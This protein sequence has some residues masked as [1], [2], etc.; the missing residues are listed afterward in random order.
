MQSQSNSSF[1]YIFFVV[2]LIISFEQNLY[3]QEI[4]SLVSDT[5]QVIEIKKEPKI[6][7]SGAVWRS[8]VLPG[9]GQLY[10]ESYW[11]APIFF[12]AFATLGTMIVYNHIKYN[13]FADIV[14]HLDKDD[15]LYQNRKLWREYYRDNR[16]ISGFYLIVTYILATIDAYVGAHLYEF[17]INDDISINLGLTSKEFIPLVSINLHLK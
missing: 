10:V 8:L 5:S 15:P 2:L 11:K 12:G 16:D 9:W 6:S 14:D 7:P 1:I 4:D 13:E 17:D 3:A